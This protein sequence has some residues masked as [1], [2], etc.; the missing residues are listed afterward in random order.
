MSAIYAILPA[1]SLL[2]SSVYRC[3][4]TPF[5]WQPPDRV[6]QVVWTLLAIT[7]GVAGVKLYDLN[8]QETSTVFV[9]LCALFGTGWAIA[10]RLCNQYATLAYV[11]LTLVT[12]F[13]LQGRLEEVA[14]NPSQE[15][16]A[17]SAKAWLNPLVVWLC[18]AAALAAYATVPLWA[19]NL[20]K[21]V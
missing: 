10:N 4:P 9:G 6:F 14:A 19:P 15:A 3:R 11:I 18:V 12:V 20:V 17:K 8:D 1:A 13:W 5:V 21:G 16:T 7:T 2:F